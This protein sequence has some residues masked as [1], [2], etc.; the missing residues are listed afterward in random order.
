MEEKSVDP[1]LDAFLSKPVTVDEHNKDGDRSHLAQDSEIHEELEL[2]SQAQRDEILSLLCDLN[3]NMIDGDKLNRMQQLNDATKE[4]ADQVIML[5][6]SLRAASFSKVIT[7]N[8]MNMV[9][10][11]LLDGDDQKAIDNMLDDELLVSEMNVFFGT[12]LSKLGRLRGP[13]MW[14]VYL[15][16]AWRKQKRERY[17]VQTKFRPQPPGSHAPSTVSTADGGTV[18]DGKNYATDKVATVLLGKQNE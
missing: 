18:A 5:C 4:E 15:L 17:H 16:A 3:P 12:V 7:K 11:E 6:K 2:C 14:G 1:H 8:I 10:G 9:T 13:F